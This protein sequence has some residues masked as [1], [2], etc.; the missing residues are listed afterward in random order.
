MTSVSGSHPN[1][2]K[3]G[4][5]REKNESYFNRADMKINE[6]KEKLKTAK[7]DGMDVKERQRL[8]N[9]V[10]AQQSRIKKK[11]EVIF[12]NELIK[13]RDAKMVKMHDLI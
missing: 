11:E 1:P 10:S 8:R 6:I 5:K 12:L 2:K 9:Q 7:M 4:R 13:A 3:R